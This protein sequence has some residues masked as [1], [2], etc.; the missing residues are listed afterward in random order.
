M[1]RTTYFSALT[2]APVSGCRLKKET[3]HCPSLSKLPRAFSTRGAVTAK[4]T[5]GWAAEIT[6]RK[7]IHLPHENILALLLF[8][9]T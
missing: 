2:E 8:L 9:L 6:L 4:D 5:E 3:K 1:P 7:R